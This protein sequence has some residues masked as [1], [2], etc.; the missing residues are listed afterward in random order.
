M[1]TPA[2]IEKVSTARSGADVN[3]AA[4]TGLM[5]D[6]AR[7]RLEKFGRNSMPDTGV[8]PS[9]REFE[10]LWASVP[11]MVEAAIVLEPSLGKC[12]EASVSTESVWVIPT[13]EELMIAQHTLALVRL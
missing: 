2:V 8:H 11:W 13:N 1:P 12:T 3:G 5:S 10:K 4:P 7:H 6:E 9:R